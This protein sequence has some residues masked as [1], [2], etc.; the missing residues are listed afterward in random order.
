MAV[1]LAYVGGGGDQFCLISRK[2]EVN[3]FQLLLLTPSR[4]M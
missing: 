4:R 3:L 1:F 2:K